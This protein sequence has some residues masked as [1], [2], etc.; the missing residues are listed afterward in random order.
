MEGQTLVVECRFFTVA[1]LA[2]KTA[3]SK[4]TWRSRIS[5]REI[6]SVKCGKNIRVRAGDFEAWIRQRLIPST[7]SDSV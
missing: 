7:G 1:D 4:S 5:R 3:E 6:V 2:R